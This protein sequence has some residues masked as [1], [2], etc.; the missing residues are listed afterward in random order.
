MKQV[1]FN[2]I[3]AQNV[4][5]IIM[6]QVFEI[7]DKET[8]D[9]LLASASYGTLA[10]CADD[11][12]YSLPINFVQ[13]GEDIYF[14][15]SK[16]GRK[17]DILKENRAASFSVVESHAI[18]QSYFSSTDELACPATH[19][20][21]SIMIDGE[22]EFVEAY[23]EKVQ[24]LTALMQKLQPEGKYKPL[25]QEAY[26]KAINATTIYKLIPEMTRAKYKFGQHL[27]EERFE[28]VLSHLEQRANEMDEETAIMMK[29]LR[30]ERCN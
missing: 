21:K 10:I 5:R 15:G 28:M 11:K 30:S 17:M 29:T 9:G 12:P 26:K 1:H 20:F 14:H 27:S 22:I 19:F 23:D 4:E 6:K 2:R 3:I 7:K 16:S 24:A 8:I 13:I 18:I 25:S